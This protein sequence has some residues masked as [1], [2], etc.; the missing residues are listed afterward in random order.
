MS[1]TSSTSI[2]A[3]LQAHPFLAGLPD[4][5]YGMLAG[6]SE[7]V[8]I[9]EDEFLMR[10]NRSAD[11]F[12]LLQKGLVSMRCNLAA[13]HTQTIETIAAPGAVGW[14]WLMPPHKAL[15]DVVAVKPTSAI[16]VHAA[17]FMGEIEAD[18]AF[19]YEMYKRFMAVV[20]DRLQS[21][22]MQMMDMYAAPGGHF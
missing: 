20:V 3:Q 13:Q 11:Y 14:S 2:M 12:Y 7:V 22:R 17:C 15:F 21:S 10:Q 19:A 8:S 16:L 6:C 9:A 4:E 5:Y 1:E 18:H